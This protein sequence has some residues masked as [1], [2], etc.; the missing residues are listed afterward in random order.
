MVAGR[1]LGPMPGQ[2]GVHCLDDVAAEAEI[3]QHGLGIGPEKPLGW[4]SGRCEPHPLEALQAADHE[5]SDL[6][7]TGPRFCGPEIDNS[8]LL[9]LQPDRGIEPGPP[10]RIYLPLQRRTDRLLRLGAKLERHEVLGTRAHASA[11]IVAGK[12]EVAA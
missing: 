1:S 2:R 11:D 6:R 3:A 8:A 5:A 9:G 4:T 7:I 12:N 10:L